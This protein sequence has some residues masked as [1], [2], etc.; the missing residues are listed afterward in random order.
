MQP[1]VHWCLEYES[2]G[3]TAA[4]AGACDMPKCHFY[5]FSS[6]GPSASISLAL[7]N[8]FWEF[9]PL[10]STLLLSWRKGKS[11]LCLHVSALLRVLGILKGNAVGQ[12]NRHENKTE[13][14]GG[15]RL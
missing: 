4:A 3:V 12:R 5:A 10:P 6:V 7:W 1:P 8:A 13:G 2:L 11:A 15:K 14:L 9:E